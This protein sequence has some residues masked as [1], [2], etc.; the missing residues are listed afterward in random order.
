MSHN[1]SNRE[2]KQKNDSIQL[3][4][5]VDEGQTPRHAPILMCAHRYLLSL[6]ALLFCASAAA[7]DNVQ[8]VSSRPAASPSGRYTAVVDRLLK[9][10]DNEPDQFSGAMLLRISDNSTSSVLHQQYLEGTQ[11]R[12][13]EPPT[14][15]DD[16][17]CAYTYNVAKSANGI[18]YMNADAG[19]G[20]QV[21]LVAPPRRMAASNTVEQEVTSLDVTVLGTTG[22]AHLHNVPWKGGSAFPLRLSPLPR[23]EKKPFGKPFIEE[24]TRAVVDYQKLCTHN[25]ITGLD[26]EQASESFS[27][28]EKWLALLACAD[29]TP[30]LA[31]IPLEKDPSTARLLRLDADMKLNCLVPAPQADSAAQAPAA[32]PTAYSRYTT[33][34]KDDNH[35]QV[36]REVFSTENDTSHREVDYVADLGGSLKKLERPAA[37][38]AAE[39]PKQQ[40]RVKENETKVAEPKSEAAAATTH[41]RPLLQVTTRKSQPVPRVSERTPGMVPTPETTPAEPPTKK[42]GF[43]FD[44]LLP[45][46]SSPEPPGR[47]NPNDSSRQ[48]LPSAPS[49]IPEVQKTPSD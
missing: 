30:M 29:G 10:V 16:Q 38:P 41:T 25:G 40:T 24:L 6:L 17:W 19:D 14:W 3:H 27:P 42:K 5:G 8:T 23:F 7:E 15:I 47:V 39:K 20:Y 48:G 26:V 18:V 22:S 2:F 45:R 28:D 44:G 43:L 37:T 31:L 32:D 13:L 49:T 11:V 12:T 9:V 46:R 35:A 21:E 33:A 4:T 36:E 1:G 34:W